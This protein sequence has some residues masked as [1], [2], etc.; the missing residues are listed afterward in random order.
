[1]EGD[2][3]TAK[4]GQRSMTKPVVISAVVVLV[5]VFV[6]VGGFVAQAAG[7]GFLGYRTVLYDPG[8]LYVLNLTEKRRYIAVDGA[9]MKPI[10]AEGARLFRLVGGN[11]ELKGFDEDRNRW[12]NWQVETDGSHI[13]LNLSAEGCVVISELK[14]L[15]EQQTL[16]VEL[17]DLLDADQR[18]HHLGSRRVIWPRGYPGA[19]DVEGTDPV[20]S[21]EVV[22]CWMFEDAD[23]LRE[24]LRTRLQERMS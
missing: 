21:V 19:I 15:V 20:L 1:M 17:I 23:F 3:S 14:G 10:E 6:G 16:S 4:A 7:Y 24:Y 18:P 11:S 22:E 5:L 12:R 2:E 9:Q 8:E 13:F